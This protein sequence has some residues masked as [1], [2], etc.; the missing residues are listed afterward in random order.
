M[1]QL[2]IVFDSLL[3]L[4]VGY[5]LGRRHIEPT[6]GQHFS[7]QAKEKTKNFLIKSGVIEYPTQEQVDYVQSGEEKVDEARE[8]LFKKYFKP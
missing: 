5:F 2:F 1:E 6:I 7:Q 4:L 3:F 8:Q